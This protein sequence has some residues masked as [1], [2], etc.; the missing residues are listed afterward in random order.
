MS[1]VDQGPPNQET[2]AKLKALAAEA[3]RKILEFYHSGEWSVTAKADDSPVT[4]ADLASNAILMKGLAELSKDPIVSEESRP[5]EMRVGRRFWLVDPLDGTKEFIARKDT[6]VICL[7]LI[8]DGDPIFGLIHWPVTGETWHASKGQGAFGPKGERLMNRSTRQPPVAAI[9]RSA[10]SERMQ[11]FFDHFGI[12][13]IERMGSA[14]KF[15]RLAEGA[16]D[17]YPRFGPTSEWDTAAGQIIAE[18]AGCKVLSVATGE[19]LAYGKEAF[20]NKGFMAARPDLDFLGPMRTAGMLK[21]QG[22]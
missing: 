22:K 10:I 19:K 21:P 4:Q 18:E 9:S 13:D 16:I 15:C 3:G 12:K 8:Q 11:G 6:F 2:V 5:Q 20:L 17:V 14:L 7:G 1:T